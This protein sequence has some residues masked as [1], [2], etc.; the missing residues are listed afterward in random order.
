MKNYLQP[1]KV[2]DV[3][4]PSGGLTSGNFYLVGALGGVVQATAAQNETTTLNRYGAFTL[5]KAT[6]ET[7]TK[8][9]QLYWDNT[10]KKFTKTS[11]GNTKWGVA[12]ADAADVATGQVLLSGNG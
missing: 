5:A 2:V 3:V 8:G 9:D 11:S 7:W 1:G 6:G 10:A 12:F 4:A